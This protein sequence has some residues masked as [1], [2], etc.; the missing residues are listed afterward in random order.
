MKRAR[1]EKK[2]AR[3]ALDTEKRSRKKRN[4]ASK[5]ELDISMSALLAGEAVEI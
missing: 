2:A 5:L 3:L 1:E 4:T